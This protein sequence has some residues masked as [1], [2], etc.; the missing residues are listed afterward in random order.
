[1]KRQFVY[2][3]SRSDD[4][5]PELHKVPCGDRL[6]TIVSTSGALGQ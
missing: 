2:V 5:A 6:T 4:G 3:H 1:M